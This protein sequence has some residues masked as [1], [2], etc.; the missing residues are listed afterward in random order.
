MEEIEEVFEIIFPQPARMTVMDQLNPLEWFSE[1]EFRTRFRLSK[2][3]VSDLVRTMEP[4]LIHHSKRNK[5][6]PPIL[7]CCGSLRILA[8][9]AFQT[10]AGDLIHVHQS[11]ISRGFARFL[12]AILSLRSQIV[13]FPTMVGGVKEG[14]FHKIS[15]FPGVI[16]CV[17]TAATF[18]SKLRLLWNQK[19]L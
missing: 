13:A 18:T 4:Q 10:V 19:F 5:A 3:T 2:D 14:D 7:Q 11:T 15:G 16:D 17:V 1:D 8:G 6:L 12:E 9:G